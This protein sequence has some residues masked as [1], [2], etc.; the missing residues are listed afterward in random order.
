M[1]G[2]KMFKK[3]KW[4]FLFLF[5]IIALIIVSVV[6][7]N[8][9]NESKN[10]HDISFS[11]V[12]NKIKKKESFILY[13]KQTDCE[14]CKVFTPKFISVLNDNNIEAYSLNLTNL[15]DNDKEAYND[16][17]DVNGTPTV[18]FFNEGEESMIRIE[19]EQ[20][21]A[22]IKSKIESAGFIK[23]N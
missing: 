3:Y 16:L 1:R 14:H 9:S 12:T 10:V 21:K 15:S 20:T 22:R 6:F 7:S 8:I 4:L 11:E 18:L 13:I 23:T 2:V 5:F 19:G 17:F